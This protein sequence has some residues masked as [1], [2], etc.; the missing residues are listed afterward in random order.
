MWGR[1]NNYQGGNST[2]TSYLGWHT[3]WGLIYKLYGWAHDV[4]EG[5]LVIW[6]GTQRGRGFTS[7]LGGHTT[8]ERVCKLYRRAHDVGEVL[9]VI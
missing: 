2:F 9:K 5:L 4:G 7:Y 8:W 1:V 6:V 3:R